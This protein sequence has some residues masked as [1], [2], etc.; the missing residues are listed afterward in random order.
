MG[1]LIAKCWKI[2]SGFGGIVLDKLWANLGECT[3]AGQKY[4]MD[5][6]ISNLGEN[7]HGIV[8]E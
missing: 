3:S 4:E 1:E 2:G 7:S 6:G 5:W 8:A